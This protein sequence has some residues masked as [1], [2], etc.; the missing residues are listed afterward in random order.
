M[1]RWDLDSDRAELRGELGV[2]WWHVLA[3]F[4]TVAVLVIVNW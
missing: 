3:G 1:R 2:K 4:V